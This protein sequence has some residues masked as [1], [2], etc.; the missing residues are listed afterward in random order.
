MKF[1]ILYRPERSG[2]I[3]VMRKL[4]NFDKHD[5]HCAKLTSLKVFEIT[6]GCQKNKKTHAFVSAIVY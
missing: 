2:C 3:T 1:G 4:L 6:V 5:I